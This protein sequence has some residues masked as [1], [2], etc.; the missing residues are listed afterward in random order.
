MVGVGLCETTCVI[1][2]HIEPPSNTHMPDRRPHPSH[3]FPSY[4]PVTDGKYV[5]AG[6]GA[7]GMYCLDMDGNL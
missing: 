3:G 6:F 4:S 1:H 7:R 5:W 2:H